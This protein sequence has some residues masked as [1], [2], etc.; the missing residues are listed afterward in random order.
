[1]SLHIA[2]EV[3]VASSPLD[4]SNSLLDDLFEH[5]SEDYVLSEDSDTS[6]PEDELPENQPAVVGPRLNLTDTLNVHLNK[7]GGRKKVEGE[8]TR[9]RLKG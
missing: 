3:E 5:S 1:M 4:S 9:K 8:G 2:E 7:K 6:G